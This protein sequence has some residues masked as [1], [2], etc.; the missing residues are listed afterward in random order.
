MS[1]ILSL[2]GAFRSKLNPSLF[3]FRNSDGRVDGLIGVR[4]VD[5]LITGSGRFF[6]EVVEELKRRFIFGK[7]CIANSPGESFEH[8]GKTVQRG[9]DGRVITTQRNYALSL[10]HVYLDAQ[11][12][13]TPEAKATAK[14]R[15]DLRSGCGKVSWPARS[16]RPDLGF[17]LAVPQHSYA[18]EDM[19]VKSILDYNKLVNEAKRDTYGGV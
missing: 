8:C 3:L 11:Y 16:T 4:V 12:R 10:E 5:D 17:R 18:D 14:E 13:R 15:M 19:T 7:W 2:P 6:A 9:D 1:Q